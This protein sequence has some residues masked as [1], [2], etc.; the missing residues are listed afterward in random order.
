MTLLF[1]SVLHFFFVVVENIQ[2]RQFFWKN[3]LVNEFRTTM[4]RG[5]LG[6]SKWIQMKWNLDRNG[7]GIA[8]DIKKNI[9]IFKTWQKMVTK[10]GQFTKLGHF[11]FLNCPNFVTIFCQVLKI[12]IIFLDIPSNPPPIVVQNSLT[13]KFFQTN[14]WICIFSK[15]KKC[16]TEEK[17]RVISA[18]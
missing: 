17:R 3:Y 6:I 2:N 15:K 1:S 18:S 8:R 10:L 5:L 12:E 14:L 11:S 7:R 16:K 9:F 13:N 4:G